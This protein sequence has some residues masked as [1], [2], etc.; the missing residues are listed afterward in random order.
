MKREGSAWLVFQGLEA[1]GNLRAPCRAKK[2]P[3][4]RAAADARA[5]ASGD[6]ARNFRYAST[7]P[8]AE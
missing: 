5:D 3:W 7:L 4:R 2:R 8:R 1:P 6:P